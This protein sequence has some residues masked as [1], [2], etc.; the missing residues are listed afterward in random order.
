[1]TMSRERI[2]LLRSIKLQSANL[3]PI[4]QLFARPV[5]YTRLIFAVS[6]SCAFPTALLAQE[7]NQAIAFVQAPEQSFGVC[8][9]NNPDDAFA[10]AVKQCTE[11][12]ALEEDCIKMKYCSPAG[13]S[14]DIFKQHKEGPHWHDYLCGWESE[15]DLDAAVNIVCEGSAKDY[16]IECS[17]V[18]KWGPDGTRTDLE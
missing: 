4:L 7:A 18:A 1:M 2:L 6:I 15:K 10:C 9:G 17:V 8:F 13:W 5:F 12:G 16:L 3:P 14:A 11:N